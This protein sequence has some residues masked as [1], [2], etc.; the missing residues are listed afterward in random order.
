MRGAVLTGFGFN[1][2]EPGLH[3]FSRGC[4]SGTGAEVHDGNS[5]RGRLVVPNRQGQAQETRGLL[6]RRE[7]NLYRDR[8]L[9]Q[10]TELFRA[11]QRRS[12]QFRLLSE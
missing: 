3:R 12:L 4:R 6:R 5:D 2:P 7:A 1:T 11:K 10:P 8:W 9:G